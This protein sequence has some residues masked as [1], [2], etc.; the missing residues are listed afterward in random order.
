MT[1]FDSELEPMDGA[2]QVLEKFPACLCPINHS[3]D[4]VA[5]QESISP[6]PSLGSPFEIFPHDRMGN[7]PG[8]VESPIDLGGRDGYQIREYHSKLALIYA[9]FEQTT[10][11]KSA[12]EKP[13]YA[14]SYPPDA[15]A[16]CLYLQRNRPDHMRNSY[17]NELQ[18]A[19][20]QKSGATTERLGRI[21]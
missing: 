5:I 6:S 16:G 12:W 20:W 4:F 1:L 15:S 14:I 21:P 2:L 10:P 8:P 19:K 9:T 7:T 11:S 3:A 17:E 13:S 18:Y